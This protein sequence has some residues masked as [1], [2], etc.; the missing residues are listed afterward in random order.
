MD[1]ELNKQAIK[2]LLFAPIFCLMNSYWILG[3]S[4]MFLNEFNPV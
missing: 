1:N 4:Q 2:L 3:N